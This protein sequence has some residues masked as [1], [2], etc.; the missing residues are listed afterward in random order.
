MAPA[1]L[2]RRPEGLSR[3]SSFGARVKRLA[4]GSRD[5]DAGRAGGGADLG[6][7]RGG[8]PPC[9][10]ST[11]RGCARSVAR[12]SAPPQTPAPRAASR[13]RPPHGAAR[14][15]RAPPPQR[16]EQ[17]R[18]QWLQW[19]P[20]RRPASSCRAA[21]RPPLARASLPRLRRAQASLRLRGV[22]RRVSQRPPPLTP[23]PFPLPLALLYAR[24]SPPTASGV[25]SAR[26]AARAL[27]AGG[28]RGGVRGEGRGVSD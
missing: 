27:R 17:Q 16:Q 21:W 22:L 8:P 25:L 11:P 18:L 13:S 12:A 9:Q 7:L 23:L 3:R 26:A 5:E 1:P 4:H 19:I 10:R 20:G 6:A 28:R 2:S 15:C 24:C 14:P